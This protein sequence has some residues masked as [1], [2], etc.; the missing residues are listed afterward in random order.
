MKCN[1]YQ[2][3]F[4]QNIIE[5][6]RCVIELRRIEIAFEVSYLSRYL[7]FTRTGH[8]V[9]A[10]HVFKYLE[11]HNANDLAFDLCYQQVTSDQNIQSKVQEMKDLYVDAGE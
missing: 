4:Y 9:Q 11:I 10:L 1:Y 3:P 6:I 2:V 5:V 7:D 8:L